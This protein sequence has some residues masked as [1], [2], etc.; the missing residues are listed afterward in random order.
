MWDTTTY[1]FSGLLRKESFIEVK[2]RCVLTSRDNGV[3]LIS[4]ILLKFLFYVL[5]FLINSVTFLYF[6]LDR[7]ESVLHLPF[8]FMFEYFW[9]WLYVIFTVI[10]PLLI[11]FV[12]PLIVS[13][14]LIIPLR[15]SV[16]FFSF[17]VYSSFVSCPLSYLKIF[18][19]FL[20]YLFEKILFP[21]LE[22]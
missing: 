10:V 19:K 17:G 1:Y 21:T 2:I 15:M 8:L 22:I 3:Y 20:F 13:I 9:S 11:Y 14:N 4:V 12:L 7:L 6:S 5:K 18:H 16:L